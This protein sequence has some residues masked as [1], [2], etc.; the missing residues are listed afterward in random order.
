MEM[1]GSF[2]AKTHLPKLLER[3]A[4]GERIVITKHG[5]PIAVLA[6]VEEEKKKDTAKAL[7]E[8]K[9]L[10]AQMRERGPFD[11]PVTVAEIKEMVY[12]GRRN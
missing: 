7:R 3:A 12:E 6:P 4:K 5:M 9:R 1:I 11:T 2:E 8:M 10:K